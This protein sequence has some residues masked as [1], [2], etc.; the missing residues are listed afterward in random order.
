MTIRFRLYDDGLG[1]RYEFPEQESLTYFVIGEEKTQFAMA[2][3][4][5]ASGS[6]ATTTRRSTTTR[7]RS[8]RR[9]G[10]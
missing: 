5:T 9:Y 10:S 7:S 8:S 1:F 2:G 4:H 6:R 3:D